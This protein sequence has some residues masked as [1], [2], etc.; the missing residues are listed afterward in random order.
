MSALT[1]VITV[2]LAE[3]SY[4]VA[5]GDGV[6]N[7]IA[8][9]L[10]DNARRVLVVTQ[11]GIPVPE[12]FVSSDLGGRIISTIVVP[13][14]ETAKRL[15]VVGDICDAASRA[16]LRRDDVIVSVGG[17]VV[18]DV[19]GFAA[20]AYLRGVGV[21]HVPTTLLAQVDAAIGGKT[22]VNTEFGKN[23]VGAF[24]QPFAVLCD[25][26]LLR[27]LPAEQ[28]RSGRGELAKY[29]FIDP[30]G[31]DHFADY[32]SESS[33]SLV[34][35]VSFAVRVKASFVESDEFERGVGQRPRAFLNYGHTLGHAIELLTQYEVKHGD[36]VA[37]GLAY[38]A[39]VAYLLGRIDQAD[40]DA[41]DDVLRRLETYR[42][43]PQA[44]ADNQTIIDTMCRDKKSTGRLD[45]VLASSDGLELVRDVDTAIAGR[46][47]DQLRDSL[48]KDV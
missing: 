9:W 26:A 47:L 6:A 37:L 7:Q 31:I 1:N 27:S 43:W 20:S 42:T 44:L 21:V 10:P 14:G 2:D 5:V 18:S 12:A 22:G 13:D 3:R 16:Q 39:R 4:P 34:D 38:A 32:S 41:H 8:D 45:M 46:A 24:Y 19:A 15:S 40:V 36:A 48:T 30:A 17:G 25:V 33:Q 35:L 11:S 28:L 29:A 23:L